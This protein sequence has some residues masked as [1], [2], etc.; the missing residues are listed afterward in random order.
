MVFKPLSIYPE[1]SRPTL[2]NKSRLATCR[3]NYR[4]KYVYIL[5]L[6]PNLQKS[7]YPG[8]S[9]HGSSQLRKASGGKDHVK[10]RFICSQSTLTSLIETL[11]IFLSHLVVYTLILLTIS[12]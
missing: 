11:S 7:S 2:V 8:I 9:L 5:K 1:N 6:T 3:Q 10:A 4:V 12:L